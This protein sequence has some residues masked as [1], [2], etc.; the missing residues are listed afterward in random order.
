MSNSLRLCLVLCLAVPSSG[1]TQ[2]LR[3][4]PNWKGSVTEG[5]N[6]P[7]SWATYWPAAKVGDFVVQQDNWGRRRDEVVA[8]TKDTITV[9]RVIDNTLGDKSRSM[10][11]RF[12]YQVPVEKLK[13]TP[14]KSKAKASSNS[15]NSSSKSKSSKNSKK[16]DD[17][18]GD[19]KEVIKIGDQEIE[20]TRQKMGNIT[21]WYSPL[22]PFD[23]MVKQD[24]PDAKFVV[25]SY[26]RG[27]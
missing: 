23:G 19:E 3:P 14:P 18:K 17:K 10:E 6:M 11:L 26:G 2:D 9:A 25:V 21:R 20:C 16:T 7:S 8:I 24:A 5:L 1:L 27:K 12:K 15:N 22:L 4:D 13:S